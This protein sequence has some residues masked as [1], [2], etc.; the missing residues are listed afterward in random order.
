MTCNAAYN[1]LGYKILLKNNNRL[2]L[3]I[4]TTHKTLKAWAKLLIIQYNSNTLL[5]S[6]LRQLHKILEL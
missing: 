6:L 3:F 5:S 1:V 2:S 4:L